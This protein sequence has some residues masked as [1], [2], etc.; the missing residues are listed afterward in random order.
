MQFSESIDRV[1][2]EEKSVLERFYK[3]FLDRVP[4]ARPFF[5]RVDMQSQAAMLAVALTAARMAPNLQNSTVIYFRVLGRRHE[6][7]GIPPKIYERFN[8]TLLDVIAEVHGDDWNERLAAQWSAAL[9]QIAR[10]MIEG[11]ES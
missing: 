4:E 9:S 8:A 6:R 5:E 10:L 1:L 2:A 11:Y 7:K 3:V